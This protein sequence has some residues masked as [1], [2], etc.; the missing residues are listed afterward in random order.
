MDCGDGIRA[1]DSINRIEEQ[2]SESNHRSY[3]G[4]RALVACMLKRGQVCLCSRRGHA[5]ISESILSFPPSPGRAPWF[6]HGRRGLERMM[7]HSA[8]LPGKYSRAHM[9]CLWREGAS[10]LTEAVLRLTPDAH[11][12]SSIADTTTSVAFIDLQDVSSFICKDDD[13]FF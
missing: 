7:C 1:V 4:L 3:F 5:A 13:K 12:F 11:S 10:T 9:R 2:L 6:V 8:L